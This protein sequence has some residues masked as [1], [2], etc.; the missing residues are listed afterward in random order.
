MKNVELGPEELAV[1]AAARDASHPSDVQ[2]ARVRRGLDAKLA[3]GVA[4]PL[5]LSSTAVAA[6]VKLGAG[7]A[8]AAAVGT[9]VLY[10]ALPSQPEPAPAAPPSAHRARPAAAT[11][12]L[13][14]PAEPEPAMAA[15]PPETRP[16]PPPPRATYRREPAPAA[17]LA[18]ELG[19]L[20]QASAAT[21]AGDAARA[22]ELLRA[23]DR[24]YPAGQLRQERAAAGLLAHCAAGRVESARAEA[25]RFLERWPRSPLVA[26]V[27]ASC[28]SEDGSR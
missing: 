21:Q 27:R 9:T 24:A 2:R 5:L 20:T 19:L 15:P 26:R 6:V 11:P 22:A 12:A 4:A 28:A 16:A 3:A 13:A 14:P 10:V 7:L 18:G 25:R 17:D 23:Y 8:V 1:I